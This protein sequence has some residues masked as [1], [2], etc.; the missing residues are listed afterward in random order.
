[1]IERIRLVVLYGGRSAEHDVSRVSARYVA[2]CARAGGFEV[3]MVGIARSGR[4]G[5]THGPHGRFGRDVHRRCPARTWRRR[6]GRGLG[7]GLGATTRRDGGGVPCT[8]RPVRRGRHRAGALRDGRRGLRGGRV[9]SQAPYAWTRPPPRGCSPPRGCRWPGHVAL[10][11]DD[12]T[13]ETAA[14]LLAELGS[15]VFV[16]P[17]NMGSSVGISKA[18]DPAEVAEALSAG[19]RLRP[20]ADRRGVRQRAGVGGGGAGQRATAGLVARRDRARRR[21]LRLRR[22]VPERHGGAARPRPTYRTRS[23]RKS[24]VS[25]WRPPGRSTWKAWPGWTCSTTRQPYD[26]SGA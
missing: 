16:K 17:A 8:A 24:G 2:E 12:V 25:P 10:D 14:S 18:A 15:P 1:M 11:S 23:S 13:G 9:C 19:R 6:P 20:A 22:Q 4:W 26:P 3:E 5:P 21:V 7:P